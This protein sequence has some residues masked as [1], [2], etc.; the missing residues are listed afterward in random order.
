MTCAIEAFLIERNNIIT[1]SLFPILDTYDTAFWEASIKR[2]LQEYSSERQSLQSFYVPTPCSNGRTH[3]LNWAVKP[4]AAQINGLDRGFPL[5]IERIHGKHHIQLM[6]QLLDDPLS[7]SFNSF[8]TESYDFAKCTLSGNE[9]KSVSCTSLLRTVTK[10]RNFFTQ[11]GLRPWEFWA[12]VIWR[13]NSQN[14]I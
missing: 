12:A 14:E 10:Y 7:L 6:I 3:V 2:I 5:I 4:E 9:L 13:D 8:S 1:K 11:S